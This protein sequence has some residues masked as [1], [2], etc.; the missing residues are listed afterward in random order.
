[1]KAFDRDTGKPLSQEESQ[2]AEDN[3]GIWTWVIW[4]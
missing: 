2:M 4:K 3:P 1:M